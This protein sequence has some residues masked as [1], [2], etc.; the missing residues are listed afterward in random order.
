MADPPPDCK[1][2]RLSLQWMTAMTS[3]DRTSGAML[4][5]DGL[6]SAYDEEVWEMS[7]GHKAITLKGVRSN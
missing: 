3:R 4:E 6:P 2:L 5:E 1:A 7:T